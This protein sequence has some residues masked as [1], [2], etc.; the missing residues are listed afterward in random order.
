MYFV[1]FLV[2]LLY[3]YSRTWQSS[4]CLALVLLCVSPVYSMA[5]HICS[6]GLHDAHHCD[7]HEH[8]PHDVSLDHHHCHDYNI[9]KSTQ[10]HLDLSKVVCNI[11][12]KTS[13]VQDYSHRTIDITSSY[14]RNLATPILL[15][16]CKSLT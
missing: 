13:N 15:K 9:Q 5:L 8:H 3:M 6:H 1:W 14:S 7:T 4:I 12:N 10:V 2:R 11:L 16:I